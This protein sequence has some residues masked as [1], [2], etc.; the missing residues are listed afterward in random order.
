[1]WDNDPKT[2]LL[3]YVT[4][5]GI[6]AK[7]DVGRNLKERKIGTTIVAAA[8]LVICAWKILLHVILVPKTQAFF[9]LVH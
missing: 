7:N 5:T 1:M 3:D 4:I 2:I 8:P 9:A 6:T